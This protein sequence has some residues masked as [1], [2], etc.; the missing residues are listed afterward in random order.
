[1]L[2]HNGNKYAS[3][4]AWHS[5]TLKEFYKNVDNLLET[6]KYYDHCWIIYVNLK[7]MNFWD[8]KVATLNTLVFFASGIAEPNM[9]IVKR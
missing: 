5:V 8:S 3:I 2:L 4:A 9:S 7:M 6:L 1:M